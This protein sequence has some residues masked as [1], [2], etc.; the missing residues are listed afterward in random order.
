MD[1]R[2]YCTHIKL[3]EDMTKLKKTAILDD[4]GN[5]IGYEAKAKNI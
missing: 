1:Y 4:D 5:I 2:C 3:Y